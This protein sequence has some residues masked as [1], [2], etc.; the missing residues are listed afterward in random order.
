M[1]STFNNSSYWHHQL[2]TDSKGPYNWLTQSSLDTL[3]EG[4]TLTLS[5]Q[6]ESSLLFTVGKSRLK[7]SGKKDSEV[8]DPMRSGP[9]APGDLGASEASKEILR[10]KKRFIHDQQSTAQFFMKRN[11][12]LKKLREVNYLFISL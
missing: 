5:S 6:S 11:I 9:K 8:K 2:F 3:A 7:G 12:R 10:L 1:I 4:Q